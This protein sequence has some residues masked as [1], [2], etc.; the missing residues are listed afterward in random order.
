[1]AA[2]RIY[3]PFERPSIEVLVD[4][5]WLPG[6]LR[7]WSQESD[8]LVIPV[9]GVLRSIVCSFRPC[10]PHPSTGVKD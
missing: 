1:M 9:R 5:R 4:G 2:Q 7:M 3:A 8:P 10:G 6:E